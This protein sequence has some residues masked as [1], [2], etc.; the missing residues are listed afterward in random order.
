MVFGGFTGVWPVS[1]THL[2]VYKRQLLPLAMC[3]S[4]RTTWSVPVPCLPEMKA[5]SYTHLGGGGSYGGAVYLTGQTDFSKA[6]IIIKEGYL[7]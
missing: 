3:I 2:D 4:M 1:Y 5:V 6:T 7:K